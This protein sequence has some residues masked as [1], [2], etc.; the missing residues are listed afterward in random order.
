MLNKVIV[1]QLIDSDVDPDKQDIDYEIRFTDIHEDIED[2]FYDSD[3]DLLTIVENAL[4]FAKSHGLRQIII[5][6]EPEVI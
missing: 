5:M 6:T 3:D 4:A 1:K 2:E